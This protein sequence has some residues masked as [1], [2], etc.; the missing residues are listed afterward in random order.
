[1][2]LVAAAAAHWCSAPVLTVA[3]QPDRQQLTRPLMW[4][5]L[6]LPV[7]VASSA[8]S[9]AEPA[10]PVAAAAEAG[11]SAGPAAA[12]AAAAVDDDDAA[13]LAVTAGLVTVEVAAAAVGLMAHSCMQL[14]PKHSASLMTT[15]PQ[16]PRHPCEAS[17]PHQT[18]QHTTSKHVSPV[19]M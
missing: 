3:S 2:T 16:L 1:V 10:A 14:Q 15:Q 17:L 5:V 19:P 9:S 13:S 4:S 18:T 7:V 6:L 11:R 8:G 12:P